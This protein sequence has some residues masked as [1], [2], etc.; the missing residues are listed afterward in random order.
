[1]KN[2]ILI[3]LITLSVFGISSCNP[4]VPVEPVSLEINE[5]AG[6]GYKLGDQFTANLIMSDG[7]IEENVDVKWEFEQEDFNGTNPVIYYQGKVRGFGKTTITA[8]YMQN[9]LNELSS[10]SIEI[11]ANNLEGSTWVC[12]ET[13][14]KKTLT[15]SAYSK[16]SITIYDKNTDST[17]TQYDIYTWK[18]G[19]LILV[20]KDTSVS[21]EYFDSDISDGIG[22]MN[23]G[24]D[25]EYDVTAD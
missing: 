20:I 13:D 22:L 3:G 16:L 12:D 17:D 19:E 4:E 18:V 9:T 6:D 14:Y 10:E 5:D 7:S 1:M 2:L 23:D 15:F 8:I 25:L 11:T 21:A 24:Y